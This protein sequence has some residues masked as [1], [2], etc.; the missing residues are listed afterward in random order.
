MAENVRETAGQSVPQGGSREFA[1]AVVERRRRIS[2]VWLV[3]LIAAA[4][5][6][7]LVIV[8]IREK[9]PQVTVSFETAD[10]LEAGKTK[11]KYRDVDIGQLNHLSISDDRRSVVATIDFDKSATPYITDTS[12]FWVV[13]PRLDA[14]GISGLGTLI[15]GAYIEIEPGAPGKKASHFTALEDPPVVATDAPG[16]RYVLRS[17]SAES[18][19]ARTPIYFRGIRIG[20]VLGYELSQDR[21]TV[22]F[23][24]FIKQPYDELISDGGHFWRTSG[25]EVNAG[26]EGFN[27]RIG[28]L[29]SLMAGGIEFDPSPQL[30]SEEV[31]EENHPFTLFAS[32]Q[33]IGESTIAEKIPYVL[34]FDGTVRG[35]T[36]GAPVEFRG[37]RVGSVSAIRPRVDMTRNTISI[38]VSINLEP[39][40]LRPTSEIVGEENRNR[41]RYAFISALVDRGLRA[42]M[43][44][45]SLLTG[46]KIIELDF[47]PEESSASLDVSGPVPA[48]PTI[49]AALDAIT[50]SVDRILKRVE[51]LPLDKLTE[52]LRTAVISLDETLKETKNL[53][54]TT[55]KNLDPMVGDFRAAARSAQQALAEVERTTTSVD[56]SFGDSSEVRMRLAQA[57]REFTTS[58]RSIRELTDSLERNPESLIRGKSAATP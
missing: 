55:N 11:V 29:A 23:Y 58:A 46:Q 6:V 41:N 42:Q 16:R 14:T 4:I 56:N 27:L 12:K 32:K 35:L 21:S 7:W 22:D 34:Y 18:V 44:T 51:A 36:V 50:N 45:S 53:V 49:P 39:D 1:E 57:L 48:I 30:A 10:G 40:R 2:L 38:A 28:S 5:G 8:G 20:Q 54:Q 9:G 13:R 3:P 52:D 24:I 47:H 31:A 25:I 15:S 17:D 37:L 19:D 43:E 26:S 33:A